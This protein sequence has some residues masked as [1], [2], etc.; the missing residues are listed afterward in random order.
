MTDQ[1]TGVLRRYGR[2]LWAGAALLLLLVLL[3][4]VVLSGSSVGR[5]EADAQARAESLSGS[6]I[7]EELTPDLLARDITGAASR[8]LTALV[9]AVIRSDERFT[10]VRIWRLDGAL[11]YSTAQG[12]DTSVIAAD[13]RWIGRALDGRTVSV[14]SSAG[15]YHD[16]LTRPSE[17][18]FQ[19]FVP[20]T[21][22]DAGTVDGVVQ[23]DQRY[24]SIR[25]QGYRIWRQLQLVV[26]LLLIGVGVMFVRWLR[27][28]PANLEHGPQERRLGHGRRAEDQDVL[29]RAH[30]AERA[31]RE[32]EERRRELEVALAAAPT[33][34]ALEEL[35]LKLRAS[36]AER[37]ELA[38]TI[39]R[40]QATLSERDADVVLARD[41]SG[42]RADAKRINR[43]IADAESKVAAAEGKAAAAEKKTQEAAKRAIVGAERALELEARLQEAEQRVADAQKLATRVDKRGSG[44]ERVG[45]AERQTLQAQQRAKEAA[46]RATQAEKQA[47]ELSGTAAEAEKRAAASEQRALVAE[48]RVADVER[49]AAETAQLVT[50]AEGRDSADRL[51]AAKLKRTEDE[52]DQLVNRLGELEH[53]TTERATSVKGKSSGRGS[54]SSRVPVAQTTSSSDSRR[55]RSRTP[56]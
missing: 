1:T 33:T 22:S 42:S 48:Y 54:R 29:A 47:R 19:T 31:A 24:S 15:T 11:I 16:G 20:I 30:R 25:G 38:A 13:D 41:G 51:I 21:L 39:Q 49:R 45:E 10:T 55:S 56:G 26:F 3:G 32:T 37:E 23:I 36:E 52:R 9:Q 4:S 14:L 53:A 28:A 35:D 50:Q 5:A 7:E 44:A 46:E 40:L 27:R 34:A 2:F 17:D 6:F 12:D 8:H 18:L 43:L